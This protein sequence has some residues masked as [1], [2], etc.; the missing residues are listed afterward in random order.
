[1]TKKISLL[2]AAILLIGAFVISFSGCSYIENLIGKE[3]A[4]TEEIIET[5][6][7]EDDF[8]ADNL[9]ANDF[10]RDKVVILT[11]TWRNTPDYILQK[12]LKGG[13]IVNE[14]MVKAYY[15][16]AERFNVDIELSI[17]G[18][19]KVVQSTV[20]KE[21]LVGGT[22]FDIVYNHDLRTVSNATNGCFM[23]IKSMENVNLDN[24]W[25]T[26]SSKKF[27]IADKLY[28]TSSYL[29]VWSPYMNFGLYYNK[30]MADQNGIVIPYDDIVAGNWYINDVIEM[31]K[32]LKFDAN[33]DGQITPDKDNYGFVTGYHG[34]ICAQTN[35]VGS[36]IVQDS[37]GGNKLN[38]D[39]ARCSNFMD[40]MERLYDNGL[41]YYEGVESNNI[42]VFKNGRS[43]F[44]YTETRILVENRNEISFGWGILPF[45]KYDENQEKYSSAG[46]DL[47]WGV[48]R[49]VTGRTE[50]ISTVVEALSCQNYN[51]VIPVIWEKFL[52]LRL[53][54]SSVDYQM[55]CIVRDASFVNP[56]YVYADQIMSMSNLLNLWDNTESNAVV[57][58]ITENVAPA[59]IS[60]MLFVDKIKKLP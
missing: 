59:Q 7:I 19:Q 21:S 44:I 34:N 29:G 17:P 24:P 4:D 22:S 49:N 47:F 14:A 18:D 51:K 56:D 5:E 31:T 42:G 38:V 6:G 23:D 33:G 16:V 57:S 60:L 26:E 53:A 15:A 48:N 41:G 43:L 27:Q 45:P 3:E 54:E 25:W 11:P 36:F 13:D 46:Y 39:V 55:V 30:N 32:N 1:M 58:H 9:P 37:K 20:E 10:N 35:L 8:V 28:F 40:T 52:G 50:M 2:L 12:D